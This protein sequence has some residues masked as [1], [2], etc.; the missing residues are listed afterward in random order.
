MLP[1]PA[2]FAEKAAETLYLLAGDYACCSEIE[3]EGGA[4]TLLDLLCAGEGGSISAGLAI[5]KLA[6]HP[7]GA[8]ALLHTLTDHLPCR[9]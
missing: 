2:L 6:G 9:S 4:G 8:S 1:G 7:V 3:R 5:V